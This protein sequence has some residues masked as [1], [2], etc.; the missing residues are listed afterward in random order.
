MDYLLR[1]N[2]Y[3]RLAILLGLSLCVHLVILF[4]FP[5]S[6]P[7]TRHASPTSRISVLTVILPDSKPAPLTTRETAEPTLA[8]ND[9]DAGKPGNK[10]VLP[11]EDLAL[12]V[13]QH[14][15][16]LAELDERP[17]IIQN[18]PANP[19]EL[20]NFPQGGKLILR[21]WIGKDGRVVNAE[22]VSSELPPVFVDSARNGF[23]GA[24]FAPGRKH[25]QAVASV[26][27][28]AIH[29]APQQ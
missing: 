18:I 3:F 28:V 26:L 8:R 16:S 22:P 27:N 7:G 14:Y 20:Q 12:H 10:L 11:D 15:F 19:P 21:L 17:Y 23:L 13:D 4:A 1:L 24:R 25:G 2:P 6:S 29:Y 5:W 9:A